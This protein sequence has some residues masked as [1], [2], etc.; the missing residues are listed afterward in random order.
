MNY[1]ESALDPLVFEGKGNGSVSG[2]MDS[3][4]EKLFIGGFNEASDIRCLTE[5]NIGAVLTVATQKPLFYANGVSYKFI[6]VNDTF[7]AD[8][9]SSFDECFEFIDSHISSGRNVLVHCQVGV[10]RSATVVAAYLM[11]KLNI[12]VHEALAIIKAKR[13][14]IK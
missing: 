8:L 3:I 14:C 11:K 10:S 6:R 13:S 5:F 7:D 1:I 4:T 2:K 9:L 12:G